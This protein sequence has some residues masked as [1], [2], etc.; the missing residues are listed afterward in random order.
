MEAPATRII[1]SSWYSYEVDRLGSQCNMTRGGVQNRG[2]RGGRGRGRERGGEGEGEGEV[3]VIVGVAITIPVAA[4]GATATATVTAAAVAAVVVVVLVVIVVV[5]GRIGT[6]NQKGRGGKER[7]QGRRKARERVSVVMVPDVPLLIKDGWLA[8]LLTGWRTSN[9]ILICAIIMYTQSLR[10]EG[11]GGK[12]GEGRRGLYEGRVTLA[13]LL[14][15]KLFFVCP[16]SEGNRVIEELIRT[17]S[18]L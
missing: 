16:K 4:V 3:E 7:V 18:V 5:V 11:G 8:W 15:T 9:A 13:M 14:G 6:L 1:F 10:G 12:G 17:R 2:R